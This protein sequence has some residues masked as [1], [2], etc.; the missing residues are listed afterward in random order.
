MNGQGQRRGFHHVSTWIFDLDNTLYP[1]SCRLFDQIDVK[2]AAF[3]MDLLQVDHAEAR[4]IQKGFFYEHGT[5]LRGLML[6]HGVKPEDFLSFVHDIDHSAVV[7]DERLCA[8]LTGLPGRKYIF[9]NGTVA[10]AE[11]VMAR[12]GIAGCFDDIFD[13]EAAEYLPKPN[14][15]SYRMMLKRHGLEPTRAAMFED[16]SRNLG[17]CHQ[18]GM[19]TVLVTSPD[20]EDS[21]AIAS[22]S[23]HGSDAPHIDYVTDDLSGFIDEIVRWRSSVDKMDTV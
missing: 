9:T 21:A 20:N 16:I 8:A 7:A 10:H 19:T 2:M 5:T 14:I 1:A 13:I 6:E 4:R 18:L 17:P 11:K 23:G 22:R 15:E 3:I 12:I